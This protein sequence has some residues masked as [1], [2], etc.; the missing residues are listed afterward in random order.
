MEQCYNILRVLCDSAV[1][2]IRSSIKNLSYF[3][4]IL[5]PLVAN[6][7][8]SL[9]LYGLI[10]NSRHPAYPVHSRRNVEQWI[11]EPVTSNRKV[12]CYYLTNPQT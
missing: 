11:V 1:Q 2:T 12:R 7:S 6:S 5:V 3:F 8:Y 9:R 10:I 4:V